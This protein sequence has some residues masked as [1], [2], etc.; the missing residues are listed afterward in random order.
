MTLR[1]IH[2]LF[3]SLVGTNINAKSFSYGTEK[4]HNNISESLYPQIYLELPFFIEHELDIE[5]FKFAVWYLDL[6]NLQTDE[7]SIIN[8]ISK[9]HQFSNQCYKILEPKFNDLKQKSAITFEKAFMDQCSGI[10]IE[11]E[12]KDGIDINSC[13]LGILI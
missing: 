9:M 12:V 10:R 8:S 2:D 6:P 13:E 11:Y 1:K 5:I 7:N 4:Q 3:K